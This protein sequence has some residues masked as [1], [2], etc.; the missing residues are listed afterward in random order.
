MCYSGR[1]IPKFGSSKELSLDAY[2]VGI[3]KVSR[4]VGYLG[5][6]Q[7]NIWLGHV[8]LRFG[9]GCAFFWRDHPQGRDI[10]PAEFANEDCQLVNGFDDGHLSCG[11]CSCE[12]FCKPGV[13]CIAGVDQ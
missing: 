3:E 8:F 11:F 12:F 7:S 2:C 4:V 5:R 10:N 6:F 9:P 1:L 13:K